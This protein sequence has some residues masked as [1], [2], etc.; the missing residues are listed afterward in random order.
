MRGKEKFWIM[1]MNF[2]HR[3]YSVFDMDL[4][5]IGFSESIYSEDISR[6]LSGSSWL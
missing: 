2:F 6:I 5:R 3:Y 1:G 4:K